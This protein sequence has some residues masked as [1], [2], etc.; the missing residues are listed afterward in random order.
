MTDLSTASPADGSDRY[1]KQFFG[2]PRGL[3]TLFFTEMWERFSYYGGRALLILFMTA[4]IAEGGLGMDAATAAP[5]YGIY[6][7]AVYLFAMPGGWIAD[8]LIGQR[9]SVLWGGVLIA[10]GNF[11]LATPGLA[12]FYLG[13]ILIVLGTGLLKPNV[14]AIVGDLY[15]EGGARRDAGFS[16]FYMGINIGA[17]IAPLIVGGLGEKV[18]W[19]LGFAA[20]GIGMVFGLIQYRYGFKFLGEAGALKDEARS[21]RSQALRMAGLGVAAVLAIA[22]VLYWLSSAGILNIT[23]QGAAQATGV[24]ILGV[25]VLFFASVLAFGHLESI[26][27]KRVVVIFFL[28]I[29][30]AIFWAGFEQAASSLNLFADQRTDRVLFGWE[31][32]TT[33]LQSVN[34]LFIIS[35]APVFA[36]LWV[37]LG[38]RDPSIP[39]KFGLGLVLLGMGFFVVAW[40]AT[41]TTPEMAESAA[42]G[43]SPAW[44][45][46]TYFLHTCGELCLSPVGLSSITKL[47]PP[48]YVGQMMGTWFLGAA[49][50]NLIA[51]LVAGYFDTLPLPGLFA[52][53]AITVVVA[54]IFFFIFSRPINKLIGGRV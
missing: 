26:E 3:S 40:A 44:L 37:W 21:S 19:H 33:W 53:V 35:M 36:W 11:S 12:F 18:N 50:G 6:V 41:Y 4:S 10:A 27:K 8:R 13:L 7:A 16:I 15:P 31:A 9:N 54:G 2:H 5:I 52:W 30:A 43:V 38:S 14:S 29:G 51:G 42:L 49:L 23:I 32:P 20:A 48:K 28:F 39:V 17:F 47:S 24:I 1:D 45:I 34:P 25:A 22:A 46:A